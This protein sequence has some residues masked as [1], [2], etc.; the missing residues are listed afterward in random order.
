MPQ[1]QQKIVI[2]GAGPTGL[3]AGYRLKELGYTNV[4]I[5]EGDGTEGLPEEAPFDA[6]IASAVNDGSNRRTPGTNPR[7]IAIQEP[8]NVAWTATLHMLPANRETASAMR[9]AA[10]LRSSSR[11]RTS[12]SAPMLR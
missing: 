2:I 1:Q 5:L 6:I 10:V 11:R 12:S 3:A 9:S 4:D 8:K 7:L